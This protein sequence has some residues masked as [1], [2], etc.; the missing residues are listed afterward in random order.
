MRNVSKIQDFALLLQGTYNELE[1]KYSEKHIVE[2]IHYHGI[3]QLVNQA[4]I[5][6]QAL[7]AQISQNIKMSAALELVK[8]SALDNLFKAFSEA[9]LHRHL[10]FKGSALAHSLYEEP[11]LRPRT[12][13]D[14]L[15]DKAEFGQYKAILQK[16]GYQQLL[17]I[18][19]KYVSYQS[20]FV[21]TLTN[22][23]K[24]IIDVH[25]RISNRQLLANCLS[26][27]ELL[28]SATQLNENIPIPNSVHNLLIAAIH[29]IGHHAHEE[30]IIW[31]Y[32]MHLLC[33]TLDQ[34]QWRQLLDIAKQKGLINMLHEALITCQKLLATNIPQ[35]ILEQ[36]QSLLE[37]PE[38]SAFFLQRNLPEWKYFLHDLK[39]LDSPIKKL[40]LI[41]EHILP[42]PQYMMAHMNEKNLL[43][44]YIKRFING[45]K[46]VFKN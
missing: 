46:R 40:Q 23:V 32:D 7:A 42:N 8:K 1:Q 43:A 6:P 28:S 35:E 18:D 19:G 34:Q 21:K 3:T 11:W 14:V 4:N 27:Q 10:L 44:A 15:I 31:L 24:H 13:N 45:C 20:T 22:D 37:Q 26:L 2:Q 33:A 39:G 41:K 38:P 29:R 12:D 17:A 5:L 16:L 25:W 30:R 9:K 36:I